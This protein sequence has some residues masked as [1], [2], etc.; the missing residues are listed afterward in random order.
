MVCTSLGSLSRPLL[1]FL[2]SI[3]FIHPV[4]KSNFQIYVNRR[5]CTTRMVT[6]YLNPQV[7]DV[8]AL[9]KK[10]YSEGAKDNVVEEQLEAATHTIIQDMKPG[11]EKLI[12]LFENE[13]K[14]LVEVREGFIIAELTGFPVVTVLTGQPVPKLEPVPKS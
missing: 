3:L 6:L 1:Y 4:L 12:S 7:S 14:T 5:L 8:L 10:I 2:C 9:D 13:V 11:L